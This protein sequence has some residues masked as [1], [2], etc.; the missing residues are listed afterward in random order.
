MVE[1]VLQ[2]FEP[3]SVHAVLHA[4]CS[5]PVAVHRV[6]SLT[7]LLVGL[8]TRPPP[9]M[10]CAGPQDLAGWLAALGT[11]EPT[12]SKVEDWLPADPRELIRVRFGGGRWPVHPGLMARPLEVVTR[13]LRYADTADAI[14]RPHL[15]FG[16][17]DVVEVA[18]RIM[19]AE[20][21]VLAPHWG[22]A[23]ATDPAAPAV[24]SPAEV[25]AAEGLL[26]S[27]R[28]VDP[29]TTLPD[30]LFTATPAGGDRS[31]GEVHRARLVCALR[32]S[33]PQPGRTRLPFGHEHEFLSALVLPTKHGVIPV[34]GGLILPALANLT[35][36]LHAEAARLDAT[37]HRGDRSGAGVVAGLQAAVWDRVEDSLRALP[38]HI[39]SAATV[40][41]TNSTPI[42]LLAPAAR[43]VVALEVVA[44]ATPSTVA[45]AINRATRHLRR[46]APEAR[47]RPMPGVALGH[48][49]TD[50]TDRGDRLR[51]DVP[52]DAAV[53][54]GQPGALHPDV[55]VTRVVIVEGPTRPS[56]RVARGVAI[57]GVDEWC[58][59][60]GEIDDAEEL[61]AFLDELCDQPGLGELAAWA[62]RDLWAAFRQFG[63]LSLAAD[64]KIRLFVPPAD[65]TEDRHRA[66]LADRL[67]DVLTRLDLPSVADWPR[68]GLR[69][70]DSSAA[71]AMLHPY[72]LVF[73]GPALPLAVSLTEP[74]PGTHRSLAVALAT[75]LFD[76]IQ[77]VAA[78]PSTTDSDIWRELI[79]D[80]PVIVTIA[81]VHEIPGGD[82]VRF[83]ALTEREIVLV[84]SQRAVTRATSQ[85][86]QDA[87][88]EAL[89]RGAAAY[90]TVAAMPTPPAAGTPDQP[91]H[92]TG[93]PE[94][95]RAGQAFVMAW[96]TVPDLFNTVIHASPFAAG[97]TFAA[98]R[99]TRTGQARAARLVAHGLRRRR[100]PAEKFTGDAAV[101]LLR[102]VIG[103][104][105]METLTDRLGQFEPDQALTAATQH[106]ER[107]W[108]DRREQDMRH[109]FTLATD[110]DPADILE[111]LETGPATRW[112]GAPPP[113][114]SRHLCAPRRPG[115]VDWT[116][117]TGPS[118]TISPH[119]PSNWRSSPLPPRWA[120]T[121]LR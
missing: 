50:P 29:A 43:H 116:D 73:V 20:R 108:A 96:R 88:G 94:L 76:G 103:P 27:W 51:S 64:R 53:L 2:G 101:T 89:A 81:L 59:L 93:S 32:W 38:A 83:V 54:N 14:L 105:I 3:R 87:L 18:L 30:M 112:P 34:P 6:P 47:V 71:L 61:W 68:R 33:A 35:D 42:A 10:R 95:H 92:L 13:C 7:A 107:L 48:H 86:V 117:G 91:A 104:A 110:A 115:R 113:W 121:R 72:R 111:G 102:T 120:F 98:S 80:R 44:A 55:T 57:V 63:V 17:A 90:A 67:D 60:V 69:D 100:T 79:G 74:E 52:F 109:A 22:G 8:I 75:A 28:A 4:A 45:T 114:S 49:E 62:I 19:T 97:T 65:P 21:T 56:L 85:A 106:L 31:P 58:A 78:G 70:E 1:A 39:L 99:L 119:T 36:I 66:Q 16:I 12:Y 118:C 46:V 25:T 5:S 37:Q 82:L 15:G 84:C 9:G 23:P 11:V 40:D 41:T 26:E 77:A 24:V